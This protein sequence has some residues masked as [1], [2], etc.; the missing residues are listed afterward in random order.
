M[1]ALVLEAVGRLEYKDV[2]TPEPGPGE[3]LVAVKAC[4]ICSSDFDRCL[5]TGTY[6][7]PTIPGH[8]FAGKVVSVGPGVDEAFIGKRV[9]V[10]PLLPDH[11]C[12][13]CKIEAYA[14]CRNYNYHGSRCDGAFAE[15]VATPVWN[16]QE[17]NESLDYKIAAMTE[18]AAV[19]LHAV[20]AARLQP[21]ASC[22]IVG[23]GTI[24]ILAGLWAKEYGALVTFACRS[25]RKQEFLK[26]LG[27]EDFHS[28]ERQDYDASLE[29]VGNDDALESA[30]S[31]VRP[32]GAVV[33]V[34][35]PPGDKAISRKVYWRVL[36]S[37]LILKGVW[38]SSYTSK[39]NEWSE[40]LRRF[41]A[42]PD[43]FAKLITHKF[44]LRDG[45]GAFS[46]MR[47][48]GVFALKGMF[49][50]E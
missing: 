38:N 21:G 25:Q 36:R 35:N 9:A 17:F 24:G 49:V 32:A 3:A 20:K 40:V 42:K 27:F 16:L 45:L 23:T 4:G 11:T 50:N 39:G 12:D 28:G 44:E 19:A 33:L 48:E 29:C 1:K 22:L 7:F 14:R 6:H 5:K 13:Q 30:I 26:S 31:A 41:E 47:A 15:Y 8:E 37:E 10:L 18:P 46:A 43:V 34:G 2:P